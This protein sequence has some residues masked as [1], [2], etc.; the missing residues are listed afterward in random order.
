MSVPSTARRRVTSGGGAA[1]E[2]ED[3]FARAVRDALARLYDLPYLEA[4]PLGRFLEMPAAPG[5]TSVGD[6][7]RESLEAA[8]EAIRPG[9]GARTGAPAWRAHALLVMR[10]LDESDPSSIRH[11]LGISP[12]QYSR[13]HRR[14]TEAVVALLRRRWA[15]ADEHR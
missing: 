12:R 7:L 3:A 5:L 10:Y 4:H 1:G 15:V 8:I 11:A 13:D 6:R 14:A 2:P 9:K